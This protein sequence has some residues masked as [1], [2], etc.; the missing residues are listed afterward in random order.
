VE[1]YAT[2]P[3]GAMFMREDP[4][5]A[6]QLVRLIALANIDVAIETGTYLGEGSTRFIAECFLKVRPPK[7]FV[8]IEVL[9]SNWCRAKANLRAY[10]FVDCRWGSTVDIEAAIRFIETDEMLI[11]HRHYR[12]IYIDD[13]DNPIA[14][15]TSELRGQLNFSPNV[16]VSADAR[17]F[18]WEGEGLLARLLKTHRE[19]RPLVILDSAGG[20]G[21]ME[22]QIL[23]E[24]MAGKPFF[25]LLD[26]IHHIKHF[27]S[28][29]HVRQ[30]ADFD[31]VA[32]GSSWALASHLRAE[33]TYA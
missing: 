4:L 20:I 18:L 3:G 8:T 7:R 17:N 23:M 31:L 30:S 27:R 26:D 5:L 29:E 11:N 14:W 2:A 6:A 1:H 10:P 28:L 21:L 25:L 16:D 22:F 33:G 12:G 13:T 24:E 9:F 15:Y 32:Q 19:Q